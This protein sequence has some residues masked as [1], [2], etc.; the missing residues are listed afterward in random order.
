MIRWHGQEWDAATRKFQQHKLHLPCDD[1]GLG[2][3]VWLSVFFVL[4]FLRCVF[5]CSSHTC[6]CVC[7]AYYLA[8]LP[9]WNERTVQQQPTTKIV[10]HISF[11]FGIC[12]LFTYNL[13]EHRFKII[14][15][16]NFWFLNRNR[17]FSNSNRLR[18]V[19][20]MCDWFVQHDR[21]C[22]TV[23]EDE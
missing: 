14:F 3:F 16:F 20:T 4:V 10:L 13:I 11:R 12:L 7:G 1:D 8:T 6:V 18:R 17:S 21:W 5:L 15:A 23:N 2:R 19:K 9:P 22:L